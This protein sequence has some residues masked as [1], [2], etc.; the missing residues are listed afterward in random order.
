MGGTYISRNNALAFAQLTLANLRFLE[1]ALKANPHEDVHLVTQIVNSL[2]GLVVFLKEKNF[3]TAIEKLPLR[4]LA[5]DGW[6][7]VAITKGQSDTLGDLV[8]HIRKAAAHGRLRFSSDLRDPNAVILYIEDRRPN[9][10]VPNWC[11]EM[12]AK[13]MHDFCVKLI[14][15]LD[16]EIG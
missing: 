8:R 11:A 7:Q 12:T 5:N 1:G 15:R 9:D 13:Q 3:V 16:S 10:V 4:Q 6:P 14:D 2:L